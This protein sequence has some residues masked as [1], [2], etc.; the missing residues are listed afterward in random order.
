MTEQEVQFLIRQLD[1]VINNTFYTNDQKET[2]IKTLFGKFLTEENIN[3][4]TF[5]GQMQQLNSALDN[6]KSR[7]ESDYKR[8]QAVDA[9]VGVTD[10]KTTETKELWLKLKNASKTMEKTQ[11]RIANAKTQEI[12][13]EDYVDVKKEEIKDLK[14]IVND[15]EKEKNE[16]KKKYRAIMDNSNYK[17]IQKAQHTR[18]VFGEYN[19]LVKKLNVEMAKNPQDINK[20]NELNTKLTEKKAEVLSSDCIKFD[21]KDV[22]KITENGTTKDYT[23]KQL[24]DGNKSIEGFID[25]TGLEHVDGGTRTPGKS[26][27][28]REIA[29]RTNLINEINNKPELGDLKARWMSKFPA[30][31]VLTDAQLEEIINDQRT[32]YGKAIAEYKKVK[33]EMKTKKDSL[34]A[35]KREKELLEAIDDNKSVDEIW[36]MKKMFNDQEKNQL[37]ALTNNRR[38]RYEFWR[39]NGSGR[40]SSFFKSIF[41]KSKTAN[42]YKYMKVEEKKNEAK[43]K[44]DLRNSKF[45]KELVNSAVTR[46][47]NDTDKEDAY[48]KLNEKDLER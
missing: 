41:Q 31:T 10:P 43:R 34:K 21:D 19:E 29:F 27:N 4:D 13:I 22:I 14:D 24:L 46:E 47:I 40:I 6:A 16:E 15:K 18:K 20:I 2:G 11:E 7:V 45:R 38:R 32:E 25:G 37:I 48:R 8:Y 42:A 35:L 23:L 39:G 26:L 12:D 30:A 5:T 44:N 9:L 33:N 3:S 1:D 17:G 28:D 36:N